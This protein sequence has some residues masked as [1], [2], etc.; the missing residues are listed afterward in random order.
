MTK[1]FSALENEIHHRL[2][3]DLN[4]AEDVDDVRKAF[5]L[6][7]RN[8]LIQAAGEGLRFTDNDIRLLPAEGTW[9]YELTDAITAAPAYKRAA[10][11]SDLLVIINRFAESACHRYQSVHEHPDKIRARIHKEH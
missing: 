5:A 11:G 10:E 6:A 4:H 8:L 3:N 9:G 1:S 7:V 2:R